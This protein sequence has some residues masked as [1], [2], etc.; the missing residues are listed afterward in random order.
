MVGLVS[1]SNS[2]TSPL[3][4][5]SGEKKQEPNI[6]NIVLLQKVGDHTDLHHNNQNL[7]QQHHKD[8]WL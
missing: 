6:Q 3:H 1:P 7:D 5:L 8:L 2:L 4:C